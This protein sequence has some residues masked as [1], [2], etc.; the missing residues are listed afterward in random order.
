MTCLDLRDAVE[1]DENQQMCAT[2]E[3]R[4]CVPRRVAAL[5]GAAFL[6]ARELA[7]RRL[8]DGECLV[9]LAQHFLDTWRPLYPKRK[10]L[11]QRVLARDWGRCQFPGCSRP[12]VHAHH[13]RFRSQGGEDAEENLVGLCLVHH[14]RAVHG[15]YLRVTG[16]AP[17]AL[18]WEVLSAAARGPAPPVW[19]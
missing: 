1:A 19:Q 14:L 16:R 17:D 15:G 2:N 5:L 3:L 10:T 8:S 18:V 6:A 12:A 4:V 9:L 13:L 7:D 11:H